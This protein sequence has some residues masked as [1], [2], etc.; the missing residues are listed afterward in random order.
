MQDFWNSRAQELASGF[1][2]AVQRFVANLANAFDLS[3]TRILELGCG[4]GAVAADLH[5]R[6]AKVTAV[7][8]SG[9]MVQKARWLHGQPRGLRF[10][11][12][13]ICTLALSEEFDLICGVAVLHEIEQ[14]QYAQL[15]TVMDQHFAPKGCAY[16][17]ENS[18]FNPLFRML[19]QHVVG[20]YGIPRYGS[21][22][23]TP[24]DLARWR[25]IQTHFEHSARRG[26]IFYL[27]GRVDGYI[28]RSRWPRAA[29][30]CISLDQAIS[31]FGGADRLKALF[32]YY[33]TIYFAHARPS[34]EVMTTL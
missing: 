33:Q 19:R 1:D 24:F 17:L 29:N 20:R 22:H 13:D 14:S 27:F 11:E 30:L 18:Y 32:S 16:F 23:E 4:L 12:S 9:E 34:L 5:R 8:F 7:D 6:G 3:E 28:L 25:L 31:G 26:E 15:L 21:V 10:L 2:W